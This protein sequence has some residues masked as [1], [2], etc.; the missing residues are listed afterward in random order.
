MLGLKLGIRG[1][2]FGGFGVLLFFCTALAG[3]AVLQL[4]ELSSQ[5]DALTS[6]S[7]NSVRVGDMLNELEAI[8]RA[9]LRYAFDH[10]DASFAEAEKR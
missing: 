2:L 10:D 1:R 9:S 7:K 6:R 3:F 8:R 4:S 5:V